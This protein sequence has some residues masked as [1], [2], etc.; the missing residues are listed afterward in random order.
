[1]LAALGTQRDRFADA[2]Q[3]QAHTGIAPVLERSGKTQHVHVRYA[4]PKFLRQ[5]FHEW[6][7][8][9]RER[10]Q[11]AKLYYE[12][13]RSKGKDHHMAVRTL[14]FKWQRI[15]F[16]CWQDGKP[17]DE[18]VYIA[19]LKKRGSPLGA[20]LGLDIEYKKVAGFYKPALPGS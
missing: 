9:S 14:A 13:Q 1:M 15:L 12:Q 18:Q 10:S 17:Y 8:F 3:L 20:L 19:S 16:R 7:N 11:W 4:C 5:T 6:A 2:S